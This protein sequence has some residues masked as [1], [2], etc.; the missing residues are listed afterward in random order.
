M[1]RS[2]CFAV[3]VIATLGAV[4]LRLTRRCTRTILPLRSKIAG[5]HGV[6]PTKGGYAQDCW[7]CFLALLTIPAGASGQL[8]AFTELF[9]RTCMQHFY[10]QDKLR[11]EMAQHPALAG[12]QAAFFLGGTDGAAW[13]VERSG[14]KFVVS[15]REDGL[16]AVFAQRA[17]ASEVQR[18]F[19][20]IVGRSPGAANGGHAQQRRA[21]QRNDE[22]GF[23]RVDPGA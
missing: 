3:V 9:A 23:V 22:Y 5:E 6:R 21:K 20:A 2:K 14:A 16:C 19:S 7:C 18:N 12:E 10:S 11:Q 1:C 15:V 17:Q 13:Q 4:R 8:D